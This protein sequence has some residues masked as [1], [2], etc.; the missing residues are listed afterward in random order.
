M[1]N[2]L[3][4]TAISEAIK[5]AITTAHVITLLA[6]QKP[7]PDALG[8][9]TALSLFLKR[10]GK[11]TEIIYPG[12]GRDPLPY[13][14][15]DLREN[16]HTFIP[17][18]IISCD[19]PVKERL[20]F[21]EEFEGISHINIDHHLFNTMP[22]TIQLVDTATTSTC[23]LIERLFSSW[24][25][26]ISPAMAEALLFGIMCDTLNFKVPGTNAA[27]L[28]TAANLIDAG[29]NLTTLNRGFI[30]HHNPKVLSLWGALLASVQH[31]AD[32]SVI[33]AVCPDALLAAHGL[34]DQA[35]N[36]FV[37]LLAQTLSND[38]SILFYCH[39]GKSKASLRSKKSNVNAIARHFG[40]GGHLLASGITSPLP[41]DTLV[42]EVMATIKSF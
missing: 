3:T 40:G 18:L 21:P 31:T 39:G 20:Y 25:T 36:G 11:K 19:T 10:E 1:N 14:I 42:K 2:H 29:A 6:H 26:V 32:N 34:N 27:T 24:N 5:K 8:A 41:L 28:R 4:F 9:C 17:D 12:H 35:L 13:E 23:E 16:C 33:W 15:A 22:A 38:I 7:D 37:A 30:V